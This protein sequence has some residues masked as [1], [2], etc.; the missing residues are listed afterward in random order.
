MYALPIKYKDFNGVDMEETYY[1]NITSSELTE[2][3]L[4]TPG[5]YGAYIEKIVAAKDVPTLSKLFKDLVLMSYGEKSDDGK[6]FVKVA[7]DGH[8]LADD[9]VQSAAYD[10]LYMMLVTDDKEAAKFVNGIIPQGLDQKAIEASKAN[11]PALKG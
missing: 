3:Q 2:L 6:R 8:K 1:F 4:N 10:A 11:H 7:R 9:F 5:G